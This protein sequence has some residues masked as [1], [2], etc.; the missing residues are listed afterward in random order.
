[1]LPAFAPAVPRWK[2]RISGLFYGKVRGGPDEMP[3]RQQELEAGDWKLGAGS[4]ELPYI[5]RGAFP[6]P[7]RMPGWSAGS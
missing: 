2:L 6:A 5:S 4:W 1:M 3:E 7:A